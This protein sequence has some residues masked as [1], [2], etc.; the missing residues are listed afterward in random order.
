MGSR[1]TATAEVLGA[2]IP[3]GA[4]FTVCTDFWHSYDRV[5]ANEKRKIGKAHTYTVESMNNQL[6]CYLARLKRK[7][8][9]FSKDAENLRDSLLFVF[10]RRLGCELTEQK[11]ALVC[12][13]LWDP[14]MSIP[15]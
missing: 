1:D 13:R 6:R 7:T 14:D 12:K 9:N 4:E 10:H 11:A 2:Q 15:I 8:H 5:F 3:S